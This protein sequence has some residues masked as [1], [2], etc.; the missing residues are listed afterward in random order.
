MICTV[1]EYLWNRTEPVENR[2]EVATMTEILTDQRRPDT[3]C[4]HCDST[5]L[6]V[7]TMT[8]GGYLC[9]D[10]RYGFVDQRKS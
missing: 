1:C 9:L 8:E 4:P 5:N 2:D 3:H 7:S 10:C 6:F